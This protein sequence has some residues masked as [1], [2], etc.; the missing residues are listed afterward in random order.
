MHH[1]GWEC[2]FT[3]AV[4]YQDGSSKIVKAESDFFAAFI[5]NLVRFFESGKPAV[6]PEDTIAV[7][8]LIEYGTKAANTPFQWVELPV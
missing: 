3:L 4:K 8:T 7:I 6:Q 5:Q 1:F 2:P